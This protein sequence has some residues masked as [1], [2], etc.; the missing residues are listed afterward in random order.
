MVCV[1][2]GRATAGHQWTEA[3]I[4]RLAALT[5]TKPQLDAWR[6]HVDGFGYGRVAQI[7]MISRDSARDRIQAANARIR[8]HIEHD[9]PQLHQA[10][11]EA[12]ANG[13]DPH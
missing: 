3:R 11:R 9:T 7:L 12:D 2:A 1:T 6:L 10:L 5:L 4:R 8:H 13:L